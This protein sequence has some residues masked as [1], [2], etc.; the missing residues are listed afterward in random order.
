MAHPI[1]NVFLALFIRHLHPYLFKSVYDAE[2]PEG[3]KLGPMLKMEFIL[4]GQPISR[5]QTFAHIFPS[6]LY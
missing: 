5:I 4:K 3:I 2:G 6:L 1:L